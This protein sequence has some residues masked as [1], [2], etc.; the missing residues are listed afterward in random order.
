MA[1]IIIRSKT[2]ERITGLC[3]YEYS[4]HSTWYDKAG[5]LRITSQ[6][7]SRKKAHQLIKEHGL[8]A[9]YERPE[10]KIYDTPDQ[11]FKALF[12]EGVKSAYQKKLIESVDE[13][14]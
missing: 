13:I 10:G 5:R 6:L 9:Q 11:S 8:I 7:I 4:R 2:V 14:S 3:C 12:P 1:I